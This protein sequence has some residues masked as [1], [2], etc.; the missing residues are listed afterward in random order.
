[1]KISHLYFLG[2][3]AVPGL[4][5]VARAKGLGPGSLGADLKSAVFSRSPK[6][7]DGILKKRFD[8]KYDN[9]LPELPD[10]WP[11]ITAVE[12]KKS[13][14]TRD[15]IIRPRGD[16]ATRDDP[17]DFA[18]YLFMG[19]KI[20][21][22]GSAAVNWFSLVNSCQQFTDQVG[23]GIQCVFG[24]ISQVIAI[25][26]LTYQAVEWRGQLATH[27]NNNGW[28][29]PGINKRDEWARIMA[30]HLSDGLNAEVQHLGTW[31][32]IETI[33][34][35]DSGPAT[36]R[37]V[38]GVKGGGQN[39]H[40]TYMG[41][42]DGGKDSFK[43]GLGN[44]GFQPNNKER[45][46][47]VNPPK[48][49]NF[50]FQT[51][52][53]DFEVQSAAMSNAVEWSWMSRNDTLEFFNIYNSIKCYLDTPFSDF[54]LEWDDNGISFQ[55]YDSHQDITLSAGIMS[56]F[57]ASEESAIRSMAITGGIGNNKC[58]AF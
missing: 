51:G 48:N 1:M 12:E 10:G 23:N 36:P 18:R 33:Q 49:D 25:A 53:I 30:R 14:K 54:G 16:V 44:G 55:V 47:R 26:T 13:S 21:A 52:G 41:R 57:S 37:E 4:A 32:G 35:R 17:G 39:F 11:N 46:Q 40:F 15:L 50:Y 27:L 9:Y 8:I 20:Y 38:F 3:L 2:S 7:L 5:V 56:P 34:K 43:L 45:R 28:Y 19:L 29:V 22:I 31:D 42:D 6:A 58:G 24:A